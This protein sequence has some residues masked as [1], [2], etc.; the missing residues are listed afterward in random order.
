[1]HAYLR[2]LLCVT[3]GAAAACSPSDDSGLAASADEQSEVAAA[4]AGLTADFRD[5]LRN[6]G[7]DEAALARDDLAG[8]SFG[9]RAFAGQVVKRQP[10]VFIHGNADKALGTAPGQTGWTASVAHFQS[11]GY[12]GAELYGTTWGAASIADAPQAYHSREN[13]TRVRS[14][15]EAVRAYTGSAK[16]DVVA[17]SMGV[18]LARKAIL[19]GP[20]RDALAG[21]D[22]DLGPP[23]TGIVDAFVGIAGANLGLTSCF[24]TG[25]TTPTCGATN[26]F[27]PGALFFGAVVG[28][29]AF[30]DGL[31][32][33]RRFEGSFRYSIHSTVDEVVGGGG[34]V[35]G[36]FTG[37]L[38]GQTG[39]K[40]YGSFPYGHFGVKDRTAEV[41]LRMVRDHVV[42]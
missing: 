37:R 36:Q 13:L 39:E 26:G 18:T 35:Y 28:R 27:Y 8:G 21:G 19:G 32:A 10:V 25:P 24:V 23:L 30:L 40:V 15:L 29:S 17:H 16:I 6:N 5:F 34:L 42:P 38:P 20:A 12:T 22:Y 41:Q 9:G 14:F 11:Q 2:T 33:Q 3:L 4:P 1:M 31:L 7:F